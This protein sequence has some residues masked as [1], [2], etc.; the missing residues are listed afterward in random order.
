MMGQWMMLGEVFGLVGFSGLP[1]DGELALV[2]PVSNPVE[3]HAHGFGSALLNCIVG[4][5]FIA[6]VVC[7]DDRVLRG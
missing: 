7:F 5:A 1:V 2:Y 4:S 3:T 6:F